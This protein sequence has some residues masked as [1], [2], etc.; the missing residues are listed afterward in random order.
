MTRENKLWM[1]ALAAAILIPATVVGVQVLGYQDLQ[2]ISAPGNPGAG[3]L[4]FYAVTGALGCKTSA[5]ANCL[6]APP[7]GTAGGDLSGTYPNPT[8]AG[9]FSVP[10]C[11]GY[12][13]TNGQVVEYTTGGTPNPC[14]SA[15][16]SSAGSTFQVGGTN[17]TSQT[18]VNFQ[19][20]SGVTITNPSA[21]NISIA[22]SGGSGGLAQIGQSVIGTGSS[23]LCSIA[24]M[25][26]SI[27][28]GSIPGTYSQL[29]V[30]AIGGTG[31]SAD[32]DNIDIIFN[33][34]TGSDYAYQYINGA[35][36]VS[37]G[38]SGAQTSLYAGTLGGAS[39]ASGD[40]G[41]LFVQLPGYATAFNK[42][43][44]STSENPTA[45]PGVNGRGANYSGGFWHSTSAITSFTLTP[46]SGSAFSA[47]TVVTL[48]GVQ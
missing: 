12:T 20:G 39:A 24:S 19:A 37:G 48:Y 23:G 33:A 18:T 31:K 27:T 11:S 42:Q 40:A 15:V 1:V 45:S 44:L 5:G 43:L 36:S 47:G 17:L 9:L 26:L 7:S 32:S 14:Y 28:C 21:G 3:S 25:N 29:Q 4:R 13:P 30:W 34:D 46:S 8:V 38:Q 10:F 35:S 2:I 22:A 6:T 41:S 16:S